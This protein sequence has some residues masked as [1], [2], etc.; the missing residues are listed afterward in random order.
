M[1]VNKRRRPQRT[2]VVLGRFDSVL[3]L[4]VA[5]L[6]RAD[7]RLDV[8]ECGSA[9]RALEDVL[10][11][12]RPQVAV[13]GET[14]EP[15]M[16]EH[17][18]SI[19]P[20]TAVLVL[21]H[22]PTHDE[23]MQLLAAGANCVARSAPE[24]DLAALVRRTAQGERFLATGDGGWIERRYPA[25]A[26][27]L[28]RRQREVLGYLVKGEPYASIACGLHISYRT[29]QMHVP[30]ILDRLGVGDRSELVGMPVPDACITD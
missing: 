21:A 18:R 5:T 12:G 10:A 4:G 7:P 25:R 30:R 20:Q 26:E 1:G 6:L 13:L 24:L 11:G 27:P 2:S 17:L 8:I 15:G 3:A 23:G 22:D 19:C 28:T 29:V 16:V 9:D 14:V